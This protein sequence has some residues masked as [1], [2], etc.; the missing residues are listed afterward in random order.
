MRPSAV[1]ASH[2][3]DVLGGWGDD[4]VNVLYGTDDYVAGAE[5]MGLSADRVRMLERR[6]LSKADV[7]IVVSPELMKR[8]AGLGAQPVLVPNGCQLGFGNPVAP[9]SALRDL[10]TPVVGLIGQLSERIDLDI[11][12]EIVDAGFSL[13][14]VGPR[15]PCWEPQ[16]FTDLIAHPQVHYAGPVPAEAVPSY[17]AAIDVGITPYRE[18]LFNRASFPLKTLEYLSA[19]RPVVTTDLPAARWLRDDLACSAQAAFSDEI[20]ALAD[21]AAQFPAALRRMLANPAIDHDRPASVIAEHC[22]AF[23]ARHSWS[24]RAEA[25]AAAIG[26]PAAT[27]KCAEPQPAGTHA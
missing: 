25:F 21:G 26:L 16:R 6:A 2:I 23:A 22:R 18:S 8:W 13:L 27:R 15:D 9:L 7:T 1:V 14:V 12:Y 11:L 24:Q 4:V 19:G 20:L 3:E 17:L 10:P 5:L